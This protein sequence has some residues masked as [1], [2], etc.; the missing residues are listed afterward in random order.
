MTDDV[1]TGLRAF[2]EFAARTFPRLP[3][4]QKR[5]VI[6]HLQ[7][8][9]DVLEEQAPLGVRRVAKVLPLRRRRGAT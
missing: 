8:C 3:F 9:V 7:A 4:A 1:T 2:C 5:L 6:A